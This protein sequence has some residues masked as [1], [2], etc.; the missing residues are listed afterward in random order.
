MEPGLAG[1]ER[2]PTTALTRTGNYAA[3]HCHPVTQNVRHDD[4]NKMFWNDSN[5]KGGKEWLPQIIFIKR[6]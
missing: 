5:K 3:L 6:R 1:R 4:F 2:R